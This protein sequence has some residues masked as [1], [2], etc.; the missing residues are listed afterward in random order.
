MFK[1]NDKDTRMRSLWC[2]Y[3]LLLTYFTSFS[4]VSIVDFKQENV[5]WVWFLLG[6]PKYLPKYLSGQS[7]FKGS[8]KHSDYAQIIKT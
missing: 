6:C 4:S 1:V 7:N 5:Y 3:Y 8:S 2:L